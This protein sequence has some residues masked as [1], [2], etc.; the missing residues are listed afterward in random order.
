MT[1]AALGVMTVSAAT[2]LRTIRYTRG[3]LVVFPITP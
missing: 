3:A 1:P 2:R